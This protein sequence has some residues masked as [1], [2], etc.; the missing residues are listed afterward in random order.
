MMKWNEVQYLISEIKGQWK[1]NIIITYILIVWYMFDRILL[2]LDNRKPPA[3]FSSTLFFSPL[4]F[5][6]LLFSSTLFY[7]LLFSSLLLSS[8]LFYSLLLSCLWFNHLLF[9]IYTS[10]SILF[11]FAFLIFF[12]IRV[13]RQLILRIFCDPA[14]GIQVRECSPRF[15]FY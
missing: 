1:G 3:F 2:L 5:S 10:F 8:L 9:L 13:T 12:F 14:F 4:L 6:S 15:H 7:S 11:V